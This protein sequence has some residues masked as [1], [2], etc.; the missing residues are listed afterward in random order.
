VGAA[1]LCTPRSAA[2]DG[3][4]NLYVVDNANNRI[5]KYDDPL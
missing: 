4:R 1:S 5:L 3:S 2:M